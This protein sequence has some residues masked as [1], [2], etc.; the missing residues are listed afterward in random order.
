MHLS[1][2]TRERLSG[3]REDLRHC[4]TVD[5]LSYAKG[6]SLPT[7]DSHEWHVFEVEDEMEH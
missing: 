7:C 2:H 5:L 3:T 4:R 6:G 1:P